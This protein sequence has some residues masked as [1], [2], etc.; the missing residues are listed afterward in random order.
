M[1][2]YQKSPEAIARLSPEQYEVTQR[3]GTERPFKNEYWD[4]K[5][6]GL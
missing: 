4:S 5:E 2:N 1:R 3:N 6:P